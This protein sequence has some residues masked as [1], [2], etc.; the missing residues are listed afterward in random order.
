MDAECSAFL[1]SGGVGLDALGRGG[2]IR[3]RGGRGGVASGRREDAMPHI[4][5]KMHAGKS[6]AQKAAAAEALTQAL[7][8][9]LGST[10]DSISVAVEEVA[11]AEWRE[12]VVMVD[13]A[14][15]LEALAKK[16][17]YAVS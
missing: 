11:P 8:S 14:P 5:L 10:L 1:P 16:P 3:G 4:I 17:G 2:M 6:E 13:I 12:K 9:S 15:K 7:V